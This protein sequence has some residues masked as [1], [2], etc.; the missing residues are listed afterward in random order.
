MRPADRWGSLR[1]VVALAGSSRPR[2]RRFLYG[3]VPVCS[4]LVRAE[5]AGARSDDGVQPAVLEHVL[6]GHASAG[7]GR[8][9]D[10]GMEAIFRGL[11]YS[12]TSPEG[13]WAEGQVIVSCSVTPMSAP[14]AWWERRQWLR[15]WISFWIAGEPA[16]Q[17]GTQKPVQESRLTACSWSVPATM[18]RLLCVNSPCA[19]RRAWLP[20]WL[21]RPGCSARAWTTRAGSSGRSRGS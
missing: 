16:L 17:R 10:A 20:L 9:R 12:H 7:S 18:P 4:V 13:R 3:A 15:C 21:P 2:D 5:A 14:T 11:R 19:R 6:V 1:G 8:W